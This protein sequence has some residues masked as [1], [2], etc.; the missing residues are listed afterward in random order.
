MT[1]S[2]KNADWQF[3]EIGRSDTKGFNDPGIE[4]FTGDFEKYLARETL[5]NSNDADIFEDNLPVL[6]KYQK[7]SI[8]PSD[9]PELE[10]IKNAYKSCLELWKDYKKAKDFF[11]E[12]LKLLDKDSIDILRIDDYN[13]TGV[14]GGDDEMDKPWSIMVHSTGATSK[15]DSQGGSFGIGKDSPFAA[16]SLRM[17]FYTTVTDSDG[18]NISFAGRTKLPSFRSN[19]VLRSGNGFFGF[20]DQHSIRVRNSIPDLFVRKEKGTSLYIIGYLGSQTSW[21]DNLI[22]SILQNFWAAIYENK[23]RV[24]VDDIVLT[25]ESLEENMIKYIDPDNPE[26][27][28]Y[29]YKAYTDTFNAKYFEENLKT[30][31]KV[32]LWILMMENLPRQIAMMRHPKMVIRKRGFRVTKVP[33]AGV[34]LCDNDVGDKVLRSMEPPA[35]NDWDPSRTPNGKTVDT[36]L[37]NWIRKCLKTLNPATSTEAQDVTDLY[38]YLPDDSDSESGEPGGDHYKRIPDELET[39]VQIQKLVDE[40]ITDV[41]IIKIENAI[42]TPQNEPGIIES[43]GGGNHGGGSGGNGA[44]TGTAQ[45]GKSNAEF[46]IIKLSV[47]SFVISTDKDIMN[48]LIHVHRNEQK[49]VNLHINFIGED[50]ITPTQLVS[51]HNIDTKSLYEINKNV[52][53]N[54][55]LNKETDTKISIALKSKMKLSIEVTGYEKQ[56]TLLSASSIEL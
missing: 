54:V 13:T 2:I 52:I 10:S 41:S 51:A 16:S 28:Y 35:H 3:S 42:L 20:E 50:L 21:R 8:K 4:T 32:K 19:G 7:F 46:K 9:L 22:K 45:G 40:K 44:G 17:V 38:K 15:H 39:S 53:K 25:K 49:V 36:E 6:V 34:F 5:Q 1:E 23:I 31:G 27:D 29:F 11:E 56:Q 43:S 18:N 55:I 14:I 48:Y 30:L 24:Q 37:S 12:A 47:R 33:F 26:S